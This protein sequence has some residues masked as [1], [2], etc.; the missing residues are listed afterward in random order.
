MFV[1]VFAR[2]KGLTRLVRVQG[3]DEVAAAAAR[4]ECPR[5]VHATQ[6]GCCALAGEGEGS[7]HGRRQLQLYV[8][9][10]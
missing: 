9:R 10:V 5:R 3:R 2:V 7:M 1:F 4:D 6:P 8:C